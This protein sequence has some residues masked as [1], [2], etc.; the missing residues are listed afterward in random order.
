MSYHKVILLWWFTSNVG[1]RECS[2]NTL[3]ML[4][5]ICISQFIFFY[6]LKFNR[7]CVCPQHEPCRINCFFVWKH[8]CMYKSM[9]N[10]QKDIHGTTSVQWFI[11]NVQ[12]VRSMKFTLKALRNQIS[13]TTFK[14]VDQRVGLQN[15]HSVIAENEVIECWWFILPFGDYEYWHCT[16]LTETLGNTCKKSISEMCTIICWITEVH[17]W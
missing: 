4:Y 11:T 3:S 15:K 1:G 8:M 16:S 10:F 13:L 2:T 14:V 12:V 17:R 5:M 6:D 7:W 9:N